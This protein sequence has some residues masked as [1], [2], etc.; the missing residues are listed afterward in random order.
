VTTAHLLVCWLFAGRL[1][2]AQPASRS[3]AGEG[4]KEKVWCLLAVDL[5]PAGTIAL[6]ATRP[7]GATSN[8]QTSKEPKTKAP[9]AISLL[10]APASKHRTTSKHATHP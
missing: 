7:Q 6:P 9:Q 5:T 3:T 1:L 10:V 2:V 4:K 8:Q